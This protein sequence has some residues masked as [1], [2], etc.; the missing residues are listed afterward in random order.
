MTSLS[1]PILRRRSFAPGDLEGGVPGGWRSL[2]IGP[3]VVRRVA[4]LPNL[5]L[6]DQGAPPVAAR[7]ARRVGSVACIH[8]GTGGFRSAHA[9]RPAR[10]SPRPATGAPPPAAR[11][12]QSQVGSSLGLDRLTPAHRPQGR[13]RVAPRWLRHPWPRR[14]G[15]SDG[16]YEGAGEV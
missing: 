12:P 15:A 13:I 1:C 14:P 8:R 16:L 5:T 10:R 9:A 7:C 2:V 4:S 6:W 11:R 3:P